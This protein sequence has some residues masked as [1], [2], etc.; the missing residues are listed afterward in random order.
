MQGIELWA[1]SGFLGPQKG[2]EAKIR[3]GISHINPLIMKPNKVG[4]SLQN[5]YAYVLLGFLRF[6]A[7]FHAETARHHVQ[8]TIK[9]YISLYRNLIKKP[10]YFGVLG[11]GF[12]DQVP[13]LPQTLNPKS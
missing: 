1:A 5:A 13:T 9:L 4:I 3:I 6:A 2:T 11:P 12:L 8:G 10:Y 7:E